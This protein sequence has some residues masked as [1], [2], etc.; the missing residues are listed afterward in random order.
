MSATLEQAARSDAAA[1]AGPGAGSIWADACVE[2]FGLR[3]ARIEVEG[4][5]AELAHLGGRL[6]LVGPGQLF[7]PSD[8]T[9]R[10]DVSRE[11]LVDVI[12]GTR[13]P[14]AL[15][16]IPAASPTIPAVRERFPIVLVRPAGSCPFI[17]LDAGLDPEQALAKRRREDLRRAARRADKCGGADVVVHEP[18]EAEAPDLLERAF[19]VEAGSWKGRTGTALVHD[20]RRADFYRR[21]GAA[22]AA[23]G[24]LRVALLELGGEPA[25][26]Q[27]AVEEDGALW[28]LKIGY[29]E[30]FAQASPGQLL[31]LETLRWAAARGLE[32][33]EFLGMAAPWTR[34]WTLYERY[35]SA[36]YAYPASPRG[37]VRLGGDVAGRVARRRR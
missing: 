16:R 5:T 17:E 22:A 20:A 37:A 30:R 6:D 32:R 13:R 27:I 29:D 33:Y 24:S 34:T 21:Y 11:R 31:M 25:A 2:T 12:A 14:L 3:E 9:C 10:D 19:A 36:V 15:R 35:C 1:I 26:M 28:L 23:A 4:G 7:E 8:L 18:D